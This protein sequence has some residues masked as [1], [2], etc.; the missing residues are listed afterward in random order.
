MKMETYCVV[1]DWASDNGMTVCDTCALVHNLPTNYVP[2]VCGN[3]VC[4]LDHQGMPNFDGVCEH[5]EIFYS[6]IE[7]A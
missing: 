1:C 6:L 5:G 3:D 2:M 7:L 4:Y